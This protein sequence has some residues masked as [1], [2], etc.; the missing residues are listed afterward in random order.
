MSNEI[1][2]GMITI[3]GGV[4]CVFLDHYLKNKERPR[5]TPRTPPSIF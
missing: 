1:I 3:I 4:I 5:F 2:I